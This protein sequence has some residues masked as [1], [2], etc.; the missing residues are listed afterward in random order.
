MYE[1]ILPMA[2]SAER[3]KLLEEM[4]DM[5]LKDTVFIGSMARTRF[6]VINPWLRNYKPNETLYNWIKYMDLDESKRQP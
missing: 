1:K 6:Y 3:T 4:R 2:P 5:V